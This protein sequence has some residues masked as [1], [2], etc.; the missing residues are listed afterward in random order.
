MHD[1]SR[2]STTKTGELVVAAR[3]PATGRAAHA[4]GGEV[5]EEIVETD[6]VHPLWPTLDTSHRQPGD[7]S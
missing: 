7:L 6:V 1:A 2:V 5:S 3:A 4:F